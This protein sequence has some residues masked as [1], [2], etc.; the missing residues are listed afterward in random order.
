MELR[1]RPLTASQPDQKLY[2]KREVD[3]RVTQALRAGF[4]VLLEAKPG[5][6][7]TSLLNRLE[8]QKWNGDRAILINAGGAESPDELLAALAA[9]AGA[10]RDLFAQFGGL[11]RRTDPLAPP[12]ALRALRD[13]LVQNNRQLI[14]LVD[15][16]VPASVAFEIFGRHRDAVFAMPA[17]WLVVAPAGRVGEYLTPPADVFFEHID[18]IEPLAPSEIDE[19]L[20]RR[21]LPKELPPRARALVAAEHDGTPRGAVSIARQVAAE[22]PKRIA[23]RLE[24][25]SR[26]ASQ[27]GR[28]P[29]M[30]LDELATR[31]LVTATDSDILQSL[32]VSPRHLRRYFT[33]LEQAGLVE[34]VAGP[35]PSTGRPPVAY[36]LRDLSSNK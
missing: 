7:A 25:R 23:D 14:V 8:A 27:L 3:K 30:L 2:V 20:D 34:Q 35:R 16:P 33:E 11:L 10:P 36:R 5:A 1:A 26:A 32:G 9:R 28:G 21:A 24:E 19:L 18:R 6:G 29:A 12:E 31:G 22:G 15:G 17:T 4:N 13:W